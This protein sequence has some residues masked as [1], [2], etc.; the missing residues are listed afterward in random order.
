M[1]KTMLKFEAEK[2]LKKWIKMDFKPILAHPWVGFWW[3]GGFGGRLETSC[4]GLTL[5]V[6]HARH[7]GGVLRM[8]LTQ[9]T[10]P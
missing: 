10:A 8:F 6:S 5:S 4:A 1:P 9:K 3:C 2:N 7:P